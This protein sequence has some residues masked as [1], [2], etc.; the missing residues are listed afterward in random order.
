M[1]KQRALILA[2]SCILMILILLCSVS[3]GQT[4]KLETT[5]AEIKRKWHVFYVSKT[6]PEVMGS[7][8]YQSCF[9]T[10][11]QKYNLP[12]SLLVAVARGESDMNPRAESSASC[13]GIMQI[14]WPGTAKDLGITK[15]SDLFDPCKNIHAG[16]KYLSWLLD[17][18]KGDYYLSVAA[19]HH[20]PNAVSIKHVPSGAQWYAAY[21]YQHL[22]TVTSIPYRKDSKILILRFSFYKK[23]KRFVKYL[24]TNLKDA[25]FSVFKSRYYTYDVYL[26]YTNNKQKEQ[27]LIR[28]FETTGLK[29]IK[30]GRS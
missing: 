26:T 24:E 9:R 27:V 15:K 13:F 19:Y 22:N 1:K 5:E 11:A 14:K 4:P 2:S 21:I 3:F 7:I 25:A 23:A 18:F 28:L 17:R 20:G 8:P 30:G 10:A 12:I 16:A 6:Q 29:P